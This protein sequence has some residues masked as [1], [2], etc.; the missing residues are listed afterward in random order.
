M[1]T[2]GTYQIKPQWLTSQSR[3]RWH[4][5]CAQL[6][7]N[8]QPIAQSYLPLLGLAA[9]ARPQPAPGWFTFQSARFEEPDLGGQISLQSTIIIHDP[10]LGMD[11]TGSETPGFII[12]R[13]P[14]Q[15]AFVQFAWSSA[16][17]WELWIVMSNGGWSSLIIG[18]ETLDLPVLWSGSSNPNGRF[19][20]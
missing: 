4:F 7:L 8:V 20:A 16:T 9:M 1:I 6:H 17:C 12:A 5:P 19:N 13:V 15:L 10:D 14:M 3:Q 2:I 11:E 18:E